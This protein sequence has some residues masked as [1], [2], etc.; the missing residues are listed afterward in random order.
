MSWT[1][2]VID[3]GDREMMNGR[4]SRN[5]SPSATKRAVSSARLVAIVAI[6]IVGLR[7]EGVSASTVTGTDAVFIRSCP[8]LDC[9]IRATAPLGASLEIT[10]DR[11]NGFLPVIWEG[12]LGYAYSLFVS[13]EDAPP[14]LIQGDSACNQ[15]ALIFNIGIGDEPSQ[16]IIDTLVSRH[17]PATMFPMGW[18][19]LEYPDYLRQL[20]QA[21]FVI[22]TH[23]DQQRFLTSIHDRSILQDVE[24]SIDSIQSVIGRPIDPWF[25]PYAADTDQRVRSI[26]AGMGIMPVG[27]TV[28]ANDFGPEATH[29]SVFRRV[30]DAVH[31][32][33]IVELHL[34]GPSTGQSTA[35]ALRAII[36]DLRSQG[37][38]LVTVPEL[39]NPCVVESIIEP[40]E[41]VDRPPGG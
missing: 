5:G 6:V 4:L 14:W 32:G 20:D 8:S 37:F 40:V 11:E 10:G 12:E 23:G 31:P 33:A 24:T 34:D 30:M 25:T 7:P 22:G 27:W 21:G 28:T 19:A 38:D 1:S 41:I 3:N 29:D 18:W 26:V 39:A 16:T 9:D 2:R 36:D 15:V 35:A 13:D 17:V